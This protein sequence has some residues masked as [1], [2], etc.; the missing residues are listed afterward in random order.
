M[1]PKKSRK[2]K[3]TAVG[4]LLVDGKKVDGSGKIIVIYY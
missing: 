3:K 4:G 2:T 1:L